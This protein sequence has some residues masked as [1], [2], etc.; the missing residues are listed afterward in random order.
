MEAWLLLLFR[1]RVGRKI[2]FEW[3]GSIHKGVE[4]GPCP[5]K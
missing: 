3:I 5:F 4:E 2:N 1:E